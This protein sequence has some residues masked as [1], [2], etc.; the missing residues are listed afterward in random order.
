MVSSRPGCDTCDTNRL[1]QLTLFINGNNWVKQGDGTFTCDL[2]SRIQLADASVSQVYAMS[3][4][5]EGKFL[6][7]FP[8]YKVN[9]MGGTIYGTVST[10]NHIETCELIFSLSQE[11]HYG[12]L[13]HGGVQSFSTIEIL[14][15]LWR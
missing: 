3:V 15:Y 2:T 12:E 1:S 6:Q 11:R 4:M 5:S 13:S 8:N 14:V 7:I 9:F 10:S